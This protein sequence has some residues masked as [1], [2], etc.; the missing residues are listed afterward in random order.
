MLTLFMQNKTSW[1]SVHWLTTVLASAARRAAYRAIRRC[2]SS[3]R[4]DSRLDVYRP[5]LLEHKPFHVCTCII[6]L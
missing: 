5:G 1:F 6:S 2:S 3:R 4:V